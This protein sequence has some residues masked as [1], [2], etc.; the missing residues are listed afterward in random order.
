MILGRKSG[1]LRKCTRRD[2]GTPTATAV[3]VLDDGRDRGIIDR[4]RGISPGGFLLFFTNKGATAASSTA[5]AV[6]FLVNFL[7]AR[8]ARPR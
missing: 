5:T 8:Q 7:E 2:R 6:D 4:D 3:C 1:D